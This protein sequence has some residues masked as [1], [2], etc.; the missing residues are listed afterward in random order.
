MTPNV[1]IRTVKRI[2]AK[3]GIKKWSAKKRPKLTEDLA[4]GRLRWAL[5][6]A[7]WT[8]EDWKRVIWSDECSVEKSKDPRIVWVFRTP[9]EKWDKECIQTYEKGGEVK[10]MVWGC[11]WDPY[12]GTF[13]PLIVKLVNGFVYQDLLENL[14]L[15]VLQKVR[16]TTSAE[17]I[18]MEDNSRV[19]KNGVV[20]E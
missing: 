3:E 19:H 10:L 2:L 5:C 17:P 6:Y 11:F 4:P 16:E 1:S 14:L 7:D 15:P 13:V 8:E 12:R 9:F 18:F 20:K